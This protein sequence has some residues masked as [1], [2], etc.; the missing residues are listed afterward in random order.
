MQ[1]RTFSWHTIIAP[2][3]APYRT[4][5]VSLCGWRWVAPSWTRGQD[6]SQS[7]PASSAVLPPDSSWTCAVWAPPGNTQ[8]KILLTQRIILVWA[9][10][11]LHSH[12]HYA[13]W[14]TLESQWHNS[15]ANQSFPVKFSQA[16]F[17]NHFF[18]IHISLFF[19][20]LSFISWSKSSLWTPNHQAYQDFFFQFWW[21]RKPECPEETTAMWSHQKSLLYRATNLII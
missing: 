12:S 9:L 20:L 5:P 8:T 4:V 7:P 16:S 13:T 1:G 11:D 14:E 17:S 3:A 18:F 19:C 15:D 6:W 10:S 21:W 2:R